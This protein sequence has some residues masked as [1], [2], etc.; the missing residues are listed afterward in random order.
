MTYPI[1]DGWLHATL[2]FKKGEVLPKEDV[3][4]FLSTGKEI[5]LAFYAE[6]KTCVKAIYRFKT[7]PSVNP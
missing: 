7:T 5:E 6:M 1:K 3:I 4:K 2:R